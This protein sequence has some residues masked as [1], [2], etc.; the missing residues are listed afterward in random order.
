MGAG[1]RDYHLRIALVGHFD[2]PDAIIIELPVRSAPEVLGI[3][4]REL[5]IW[6]LRVRI[7]LLDQLVDLLHGLR[8]GQAVGLPSPLDHLAVAAHVI[9]VF[10]YVALVR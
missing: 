7:Q 9:A 8:R 2:A 1:E 10:R 5:D 6:L 4:A 3:F